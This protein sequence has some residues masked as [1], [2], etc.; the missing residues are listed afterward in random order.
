M[1]PGADVS[2][3]LNSTGGLFQVHLEMPGGFLYG[4]CDSA[5]CSSISAQ[6]STDDDRLSSHYRKRI[7]LLKLAVFVHEPGHGLRVSIH[8]RRRNV[9]VGTNNL[10]YHREE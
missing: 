9:S 3:S 2:K 10:T 5:A 6:R 1:G 4:N 8:V 7:V